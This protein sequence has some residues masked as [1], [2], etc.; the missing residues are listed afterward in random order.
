MSNRELYQEIHAA[1]VTISRSIR[2]GVRTMTPTDTEQLIEAESRL[3]HIFGNPVIVAA[4]ADALVDLKYERNG[5][6]ANR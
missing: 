1:V 3:E 2:P 5:L 4:I 6:I